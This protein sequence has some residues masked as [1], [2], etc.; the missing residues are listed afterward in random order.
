MAE[1]EVSRGQAAASWAVSAS[2]LHRL[3]SRSRP[4]AVRCLPSL[5]RWTMVVS[6]LSDFCVCDLWSVFKSVF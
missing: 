2:L 3:L 4:A 1:K 5:G 6:L